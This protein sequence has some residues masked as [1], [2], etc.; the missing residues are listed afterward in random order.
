[1]GMSSGFSSDP[2][3]SHRWEQAAS[4]P[5]LLVLW[6]G[7]NVTRSIEIGQSVVL[8]RG[9]DCDIQVFHGSVSRRHVEI[10]FE[11]GVSVRDLGSSNGTKVGGHKLREGEAV[12]LG[13]GVAV[14]FGAAMAVVQAPRE[15]VGVGVGMAASPSTESDADAMARA[16]TLMK[17]VAPS[18]IPVLFLGETGSG[19]DVAANTVHAA[20]PRAS[21]PLVRV[22]CAAFTEALLES[23]L[24]GHERGAFTGAVGAKPGLLEAADGGTLFFDE[25]GEMP[26]GL[27]AKLLRVLE[28]REVRRLGATRARPVDVRFLAAT[29]RDLA[30]EVQRGTFR[31]DLYYRVNGISIVI[32]PL[33]ER[34]AEIAGLANLFVADAYAR[35]GVTAQPLP[36]PTVRALI[37]YAWPGNVRELKHVIERGVLLASGGPLAPAH[38]VF[39][40]A[41][42]SM[43][44]LPPPPSSASMAPS[45]L[46]LEIERIERER[47]E[48]ALADAKG[49]QTVA[50][51]ALGL[52]RRQLISRIEAYGLPRPRKKSEIP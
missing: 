23:E 15:Q 51:K 36:L 49:N 17:L 6:E 27:Q 10:T 42:H 40:T 1:M 11:G 32:P 3:R 16:R 38:L 19:K 13:F 34:R 31:E 30:T 47:I 44:P 2:T 26:R 29:N 20:S 9:D 22:N 14:E 24:F 50:A 39:E 48:R 18:S 37:E 8:G 12:P 35:L 21:R 5:R 45:T 41:A 4:G 46:P 25:I 28:D 52:T 7:G 33:R 43:P